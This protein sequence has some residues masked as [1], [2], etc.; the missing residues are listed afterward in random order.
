MFFL[1]SHLTLL[2]VAMWVLRLDGCPNALSQMVQ[3]YGV[4]ELWVVSCFWRWAF[5]RKRLW[6]TA[7]A[8]GLSPKQYHCK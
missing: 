8:N 7:Q 1:L 5:W 4:A 2:C 3:A 6:Q